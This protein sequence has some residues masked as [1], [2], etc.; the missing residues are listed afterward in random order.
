MNRRGGSALAARRVRRIAGRPP[1][2][3]CG[4]AHHPASPSRPRE[5]R[6]A[7]EPH[8]HFGCCRP[9]D[10][11]VTHCIFPGSWGAGPP[12]SDALGDGEDA[13]RLCWTTL[14]WGLCSPALRGYKPELDE[15]RTAC[16]RRRATTLANF[17]RDLLVLRVSATRQPLFAR[18]S[19]ETM[20]VD[21][22]LSVLLDVCA[23]CRSCRGMRA[24]SHVR[25]RGN[26]SDATAELRLRPQK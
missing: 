19:H 21:E 4:S 1:V 18:L 5:G 2:V 20:A 14:R 7:G 12:R 17:A 26:V 8:A 24:G 9:G 13:G 15:P 23:A 10:R 11:A 22:A 16:C 25:Q 6:G 3:S